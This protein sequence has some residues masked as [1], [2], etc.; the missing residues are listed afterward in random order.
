[1]CRRAGDKNMDRRKKNKGGNRKRSNRRSKGG[2]RKY[3]DKQLRSN[4]NN[5]ETRN[6]ETK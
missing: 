5:K 2:T 6:E 1:M 3:K 4:H